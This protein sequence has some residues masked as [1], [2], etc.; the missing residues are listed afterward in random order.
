MAKLNPAKIRMANAIKLKRYER[1]GIK[2]FTEALKAQAVPNPSILPMQEAYIRFYQ[3]VFVDS[4][5]REWNRIRVQEKS[6]IPSDFF[7]NTW[8]EWIKD[9]V[10]QNLGFLITEVTE[11]TRKKVQEILGNAIEQG[12]NP[13]QTQALLL[14]QIPDVKRARAIARTESTRANNEGL[15]KSAEDWSRET[16]ANLY[17][18]WFWG[19]SRE[20]RIQHF[21]AQNKPIK[22]DDFFKFTDPKGN[23]VLME[24]PGDIAGGASQTINCSC[25]VVYISERFARRNYPEAFKG[26]PVQPLQ[27]QILQPQIFEQL[28]IENIPINENLILSTQD[29][30]TRKKISDILKNSD[31]VGEMMNQNNSLFAIRTPSQ[32]TKAGTSKFIKELG[33]VN[34]PFQVSWENKI[35]FSMHSSANGNCSVAGKF[36]NVKIRKGD[37]IQFVK[38]N[39][40]FSKEET[41]D[42]FKKG[43]KVVQL[44]GGNKGLYNQQKNEIIGYVDDKNNVK[45]WSVSAMMEYR[46]GKKNIATTIT[47]ESGHMMQAFKDR[48]LS[49]WKNILSQN[50]LTPKKD[51]VT[52]YSRTNFHEL[53]AE[54]YSL[55]VYDNDGLRSSNQKLYDVFTKYIQKI[56]VDLN[57]IKIAK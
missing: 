56:G 30:I 45:P 2:V 26:Q 31:G 11:T 53:F 32:A 50:G 13:F 48:D 51:G 46:L 21:E 49:R 8:R 5:K 41:E 3:E 24:K 44:R 52:E 1:F 14:D 39:S 17:K 18:L 23:V 16:G 22:K 10:L 19:G 6:F 37:E 57:T 7:L 28:E 34:Q 15:K 20:P 36:M 25:S 29:K 27:G 38:I 4:A 35:G 33:L 9:W 43:Y 55:Y 42:L 12:L 54:T 40:T 47:H